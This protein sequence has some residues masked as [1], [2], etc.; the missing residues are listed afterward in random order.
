MS[1]SARVK[2]FG[3]RRYSLWDTTWQPLPKPML[4][5]L[6]E[7][8]EAEKRLA[9]QAQVDNDDARPSG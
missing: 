5:L 1:R 7:I 2:A 8:A 6:I 3:L 9:A 4:T